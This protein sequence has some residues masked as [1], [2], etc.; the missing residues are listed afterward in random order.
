MLAA[1][2]AAGGAADARAGVGWAD[3]AAETTGRVASLG[4]SWR[5]DGFT[6]Y[7]ERM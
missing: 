4:E 5:W 2:S 7:V 3:N 1:K 6:G